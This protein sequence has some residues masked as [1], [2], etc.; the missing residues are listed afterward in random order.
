[1]PEAEQ[2]L[3]YRIRCNQ[4][5]GVQFYR[6]K[7]LLNYIVDFYCHEISLA[8]EIDGSSHDYNYFNDVDRQ[9]NL[10]EHGVV[11]LRFSNE[12]VLQNM[13][14]VSLSIEEKVN[15]LLNNLG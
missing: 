15:L 8:I 5:Q 2:K 4:I 9:G 10:E 13:F 1:M 14:S 11:F 7:P 6:L 12:D 3:W